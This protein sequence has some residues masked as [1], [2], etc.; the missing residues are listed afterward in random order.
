MNGYRILLIEDEIHLNE[1]LKMNLELDGYT[2]VSSGNGLQALHIAQEQAFDLIISD[3][4][5]PGMDGL[6]LCSTLRIQGNKTPMMIISAKGSSKERIEGLKAGANDYLPKPFDLEELLLR[7]KNLIAQKEAGI[8]PLAESASYT[9]E[10]GTVKFDAFEIIDQHGQLQS[11]SKKEMML[12][13]L[14]ITREGEAIS[15]E[16]IMDKVW[17]YDIFTSSRTID[18]FI[19]NFRKHFEKDSRHPEY[20]HSVRGIGYKFT[21]QISKA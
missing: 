8:K 18:N 13:K 5:L 11:I 17:G 21:S 15:R 10:A 3:I 14:L 2:V 4:M 16:E 7:T 12:L 20:F 6:T 1:M 9:F 19:T